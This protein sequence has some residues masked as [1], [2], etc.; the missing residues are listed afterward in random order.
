M[1]KICLFICLLGFAA[2]ANAYD[3]DVLFETNFGDI[4]IDLNYDAAPITVDNFKGYVNDGFY[5]DL[6]FHRVID[7]F[8]IQA[9]AFDA[10]LNKHEPT[11]DPIVNESYNGLSNLQYTVAMARTSQPDSATSQFYINTADNLFLDYHYNNDPCYVGYCVFGEVVS[12]M[13]VVDAIAQV[14]TH[15]TNGMNDVPEEP[16][17]IEKATVIPEPATII[18]LGLGGMLFVRRRRR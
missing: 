14:S 12:G 1:R 6:V 10:D 4:V 3:G 15:S 5:K 13:E 16:V 11:R 7:D 17:I 18:L 2:Q 8:M 9:G